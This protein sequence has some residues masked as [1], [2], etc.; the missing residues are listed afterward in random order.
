MHPVPTV[1]RT[2]VAFLQGIVVLIGI[3]ILAFLLI[4][5]NFEGRNVDATLW[6]VYFNDPF[7]AY[8]YLGSVALFVALYQAFTLLAYIGRGKVF[9]HGSVKA[10]Q[11]MK[12]CGV[13]LMAF[14][15]GAEAYFVLVVR[16]TDDIAGGVMMGLIAMLLSAILATAA[17]VFETLLRSAVAIKEEHDFTV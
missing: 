5:P 6:Q 8:A 2:Q 12:Y 14:I 3:V 1:K 9:S 10:L 16:G 17:A 4:E 13:T 7:L 15:A 11:T